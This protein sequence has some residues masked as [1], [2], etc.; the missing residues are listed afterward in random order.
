MADN[1]VKVTNKNDYLSIR[2]DRREYE[3]FKKFC[4]KKKIKVATA[5]RYFMAYSIDKNELPFSKKDIYLLQSKDSNGANPARVSLRIQNT[6]ERDKFKELCE[7][8][9]TTMAGA[10]KLFFRMCITKG[11]FPFEAE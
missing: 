6:E 2:M 3:A 1:N 9:N 4:A 8:Y 10:V 7:L 5:L 11:D